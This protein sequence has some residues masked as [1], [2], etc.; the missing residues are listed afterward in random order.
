VRILVIADD[1]LIR[2]VLQEICTQEGHDVSAVADAEEALREMKS[3]SYDVIFADLDTEAI[4]ASAI[5]GILR[6]RHLKASLIVLSTR[7]RQEIESSLGD[8][9]ISG[10]IGK[11]FEAAAVRSLIEKVR[12]RTREPEA[13]G[14]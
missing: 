10:V 12:D 6:N 7:S 5:A 9:R 11:P 1:K 4:D 2:W 14:R 3:R 13:A 8:I